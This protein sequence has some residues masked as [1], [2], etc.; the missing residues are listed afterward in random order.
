VIIRSK[1]CTSSVE[2]LGQPIRQF[3]ERE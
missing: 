1:S 3:D 2:E